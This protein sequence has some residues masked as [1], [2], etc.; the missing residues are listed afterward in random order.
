MSFAAFKF[1]LT[2]LLDRLS[3]PL[4]RAWK[5]RGKWTLPAVKEAAPFSLQLVQRFEHA[6]VSCTIDPDDQLL[7][8]AFLL[9]CLAG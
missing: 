9:L 5:D 7:L 6:C 2:V 3:S 1:Q 8:A 4:I